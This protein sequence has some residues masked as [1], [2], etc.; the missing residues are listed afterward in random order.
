MK[1]LLIPL[2]S[3]NHSYCSGALVDGRQALCHSNLRTMT[4]LRKVRRRRK[5]KSKSK[6]TAFRPNYGGYMEHTPRGHVRTYFLSEA[7]GPSILLDI[8]KFHSSR[9]FLH[10]NPEPARELVPATATLAKAVPEKCGLICS[11]FGAG[12]CLETFPPA[13]ERLMR[14]NTFLI[15]RRD[16]SP[17]RFKK[18]TSSTSQ[19]SFEQCCCL[20]IF[21]LLQSHLEVKNYHRTTPD[22]RVYE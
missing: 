14:N 7:A 11:L 10:A 5:K 4:M 16:R 22:L 13:E 8:H 19:F 21:R 9:A 17:F 6:S 20:L 15:T 3:F 2:S 1:L 12:F 18:K